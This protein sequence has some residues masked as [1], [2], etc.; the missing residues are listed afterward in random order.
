MHRLGKIPRDEDTET[1]ADAPH[2]SFE[3]HSGSLMCV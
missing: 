2:T 1:A 3:R